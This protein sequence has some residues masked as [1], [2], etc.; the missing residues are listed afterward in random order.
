VFSASAVVAYVAVG[1]A[2]VLGR[3]VTEAARDALAW[4][5]PRDCGASPLIASMVL[6]AASPTFAVVLP[7]GRAPGESKKVDKAYDC[8]VGLEV[9]DSDV[10][11]TNK[12]NKVFQRA[13]VGP[14]SFHTQVCVNEPTKKCAMVPPLTGITV[15][16]TPLAP[17]CD[18]S[19][20]HACGAEAVL[21]VAEGQ[22]L[23]IN[24]KASAASGGPDNDSFTFVCKRN[25]KKKR[26]GSTTTTCPTL[27]GGC[28]CDALPDAAC[29]KNMGGGADEVV[30]TV[31]DHGTD[32][33][34]GWSGVEHN[35][36]FPANLQFKLCLD[37]CDA[38]GT[39]TCT[40]NGSTGAGSLNGTTF[41][42]PLPVIAGGVAVC[43][44]NVFT[45]PITGMAD[46]ATG[47][48]SGE[49]DLHSE[50]FVTDATKVC[51][52]C[53]T[54][55]CDSGP[56]MG[57]PCHVDGSVPVVN[58]LASNKLF[59]LSKDCPPNGT[60]ITTL[61]IPL[62][63]TTG[64]DTTPGTGGSKP[65]PGQ[66]ADDSCSSAGCGADNCTGNACVSL[67]PDPSNPSH[68]ICVDVKGGLSQGCCNDDTTVPCFPT[69]P[70]EPGIARTGR[71]VP[72]VTV[73]GASGSFPKVSSGEVTVATFCEAATGNSNID[74]VSGLAGPG[75]IIFNTDACWTKAP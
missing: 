34:F 54:G 13:C 38:A 17:P 27:P 32:L 1:A 59:H 62:P 48:L 63:I 46:L 26:C 45:A 36:P 11:K 5:L 8:W 40:A 68:M 42:P 44:V 70:G 72:A 15:D 55:T 31:L 12:R 33:D 22:R 29:P 61:T 74:T 75:T 57:Q 69:R 39:S 16:K 50:V 2:A 10:L 9:C 47:E 7:G 65:C 67:I 37:G 43:L 51:P 18:L 56:N 53:E 41:G 14:C 60:P 20:A 64:T 19:G 35:F 71:P 66:V 52:R 24:V 49:V 6:A 3:S 4:V 30:F 25:P 23:T 73:S 28:S 21:A 58:S